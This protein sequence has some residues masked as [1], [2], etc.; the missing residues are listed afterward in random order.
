M[1]TEPC[2]QNEQ[3]KLYLEFRFSYPEKSKL[4]SLRKSSMFM[5]ENSA[6]PEPLLPPASMG[7]VMGFFHI[8]GPRNADSGLGFDDTT[9]FFFSPYSETA[10]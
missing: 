9:T 1:L 2:W 8:L 5:M 6:S 10:G 7:K 3:E 4:F